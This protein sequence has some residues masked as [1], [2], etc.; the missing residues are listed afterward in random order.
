MSDFVAKIKQFLSDG[1]SA[2]GPEPSPKPVPAQWKVDPTAKK[3]GWGANVKGGMRL[4]THMLKEVE[5]GRLKVKATGRF[6]GCIG[7]VGFPLGLMT[8]LGA[9]CT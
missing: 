7:S 1:Y 6:K 8:L 3:T 5:H 4:R 2:A 9:S